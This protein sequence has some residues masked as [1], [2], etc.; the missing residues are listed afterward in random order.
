MVFLLRERITSVAGRRCPGIS[1]P[2][3]SEVLKPCGNDKPVNQPHAFNISIYKRGR[4]QKK[5]KKKSLCTEKGSKCNVPRRCRP[6][7]ANIFTSATSFQMYIIW[8]CVFIVCNVYISLQL[9]AHINKR[10]Q[11]TDRIKSAVQLFISDSQPNDVAVASSS[12]RRGRVECTMK[13]FVWSLCKK[14]KQKRDKRKKRN[15]QKREV[16]CNPPL[17]IRECGLSGSLIFKIIN[18]LLILARHFISNKIRV[19]S[20]HFIFF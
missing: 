18:P 12:L 3:R 7:R 15:F 20:T 2:F 8:D 19:V 14:I 11:L 1:Q 6:A 10:V 16:K 9:F 4:G 17:L 13:T 5:K